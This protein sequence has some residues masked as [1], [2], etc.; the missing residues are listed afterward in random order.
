[1]KKTFILMGLL[2]GLVVNMMSLTACGDDD[3]NSNPLVG[4]WYIN[5]DNGDYEEI[6]FFD[7][8]KCVHFTESQKY[9]KETFAG[10]Y[11]ADA[12][13]LLLM[14]SDGD[15]LTLTYSISGNKMTTTKSG[16]SRSSVWTKK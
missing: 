7:D 16:G 8:G 9:G 14:W 2:F 13:K 5:E 11:K 4:T 15:T 6:T 3:D 12:N 1:M 10:T